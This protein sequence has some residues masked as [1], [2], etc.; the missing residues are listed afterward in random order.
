VKR[1]LTFTALVVAVVFVAPA[2][3]RIEHYPVN[4]TVNGSGSVTGQDPDGNK[5]NCPPKCNALMRQN[6]NITLTENPGSGSVFVGWGGE[7]SGTGSTCSFNKSDGS[8]VSVSATFDNP[9]PF[10]LTVNR[11]GTGSGSVSG[12]GINCG[13]TCSVS[14]AKGSVATLNAS[15]AT[16]STFERWEGDCSGTGSCSVT[17]DAPK[18]VTAIFTVP[19]APPTYTA[20]VSKNG[21]G[22]GTVT[23][24]GID[25][26]ATCTSSLVTGTVIT[27]T[28]AATPSYV[29]TGWGG[30]C[31]G[32]A[33]ECTFTLTADTAVTATFETPK[34]TLTIEKDGPGYVGGG[35]GI[36]C[37]PTCALTADAGTIVALVATPEAGGKF[38]GWTGATSCTTP[39]PTCTVSLGATQTIVA[40]FEPPDTAAPIV[41]PLAAKAKRGRT[42]LLRFTSEDN[43]TDPLTIAGTVRAGTK[44][45]AR[46]NKQLAHAGPGSFSYRVPLRAKGP[47][48]FCLR[49]TDAA[50]N[51]GVLACAPLKIT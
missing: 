28:A 34:Y 47:L 6:T 36:D 10:D 44:T 18:S 17:M 48:R 22:Q 46:L 7:C 15:A 26:G 20:S 31:S 35:A 19:E 43:R 27:L 12:S 39:T 16:G 51:R 38:L 4:V 1:L 14:L 23:G 24:S 3:A 32:A 42:A 40:R 50:G 41:R 5:I 9:G 29:F 49:A 30:P 11:S 21:N 2:S 33:P 45:L 25:C 13:G 8:S 37:G